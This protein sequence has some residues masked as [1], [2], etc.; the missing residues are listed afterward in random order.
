MQRGG[1][2]KLIVVALANDSPEGKV[3][4]GTH[5][6]STFSM[7]NNFNLWYDDRLKR[8]LVFCPCAK[9]AGIAKD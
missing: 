1:S 3:Y 4:G 2:F 9:V 6:I 5:I 8:T 7:W